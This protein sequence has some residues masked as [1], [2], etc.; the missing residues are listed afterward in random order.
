MKL[1]LICL[2]GLRIDLALPHVMAADERFRAPDHEADPRFST[3][4]A[5]HTLSPSQV[6]GFG[7]LA[8]TLTRLATPG[9]VGDAQVLP[10]WMTPPTDS[11]PG[12]SSLLTG[13]THE[14]C[15]VW[16]NEFVG[17]NLAQCPDILTRIWAANPMART[18][19]AADWEAFCAPQGPGPMVQQRVDQQRTGQHKAFPVPEADLFNADIEVRTKAC[20]TLNHE[21]P[22]ASIVYL[23]NT[24]HMAHEHGADSEQY[25]QAIRE[26]DEHV[27]YLVKAVAERHEALDEDWLV[28][29]LTDHGHKPEGGHG[30]DEVEVRRSFLL[31]HRFTGA[32]PQWLHDHDA[33]RSHEVCG[34]LLRT[35]GI[36]PAGWEST[37]E[38]GR[39]ADIP[40]V[41][42]SRNLT[43]EW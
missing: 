16:W 40:S 15:N 2:D 42:P 38:V 37:H 26:A 4:G 5:D 14:Q 20:W 33:L 11:G 23:Q 19:V 36:S 43:Y 8:P 1:L 22:D 30:E 39:L 10:V 41:G 7:V 13:S 21:G 25:R 28:A 29:V 18:M 27:R 3:G 9:P 17:H 35:L 32:L 24:D 6:E 12:W 31:L 34:L